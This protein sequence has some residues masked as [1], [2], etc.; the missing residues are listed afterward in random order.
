MIIYVLIFIIAFVSLAKSSGI[1]VRSLTNLSRVLNISEFTIT[2]IL[3]SFATSIPE[4]FVGISSGLG[5][6]SDFSFGNIL[7]ANFINITLV[8]GLVAFFSNG[9]V[10]ESKI[11]QKKFWLILFIA[12][13]PILLALDGTISRT[14]GFLLILFFVIYIL[15]LLGERAYF[16]KVINE[17]K[18]DHS[19]L[20]KTF[21]NIAFLFLGILIL[22]ASSI[23]IVWSGKTLANALQIGILSFGIIFVALGT[24][25]PELAFGVRA[26]MLKHS[27]MTIGNSMGSVAFNSA[28][29]VGIVSIIN[30]IH[31]K[32][33]LPFFVA[34]TFLILALLLFNIF[35]YS[36]SNIS[37]RESL[38][39]I[40]LYII[41]LVSEYC[42]QIS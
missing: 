33:P 14:E 8:I 15:N 42:L 26:S 21:K 5:G 19:I 30:P 17:I 6:I 25:L 37:R 23:L 24:T 7:G 38:I 32:N 31:I 4:L 16:T 39:L 9:L 28:F 18:L 41:F 3:M 29:I 22:L 2:F 13:L 36:R 20:T 11:S 27:S 34:A 35:I 10:I 12:L 1:L 40:L